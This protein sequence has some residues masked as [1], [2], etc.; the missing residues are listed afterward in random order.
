M[1]AHE[2]G[3]ID[4]VVVNLYPFEETVMRGADRDTVIENIDIGGPS[5][6][7]SAA[8][9]HRYVTI[10]TDPA[11]YDALYEELAANDG[12]TTARIQETHGRQG[13]CRHRHL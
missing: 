9:N 1:E 2:I 6:V 11:D 5:M 12:A 10:V 7:R 4:L 8:K 13:L 3:A